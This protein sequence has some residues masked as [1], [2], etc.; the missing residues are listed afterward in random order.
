MFRFNGGKEMRYGRCDGSDLS[1]NFV[2]PL[3]AESIFHALLVQPLATTFQV[4]DMLS[5]GFVHGDRVA[6][7]PRLKRSMPNTFGQMHLS[8]KSLSSVF[9]ISFGSEVLQC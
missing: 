1:L 8:A 2:A 5:D 6:Y 9:V 7:K 4:A 3:L